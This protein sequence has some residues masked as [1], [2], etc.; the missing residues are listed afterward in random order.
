MEEKNG[1]LEHCKWGV[2]PASVRKL[3]QTL[4]M[5]QSFIDRLYQ[6]RFRGLS[7]SAPAVTSRTT[8][9]QLVRSVLQMLQGFSSPLFYW[10]DR[11]HTFHVKNDIHVAH[12]SLSSLSDILSRFIHAANCL[13]LVEEF[14]KHIRMYSQMYP[15]TMKAFTDSVFERLKNLRKIALS[16]EEK[17]IKLDNGTKATLLALVEN[18]KCICA[19]A[20]FLLQIVREAV[21]CHYLD[22]QYSMHASELAVHI[23]DY[24]YLKLN[25]D[26]LVQD[27]EDAAYHT[28]LILFI[29]SLQPLIHGLDDWLYEGILDDPFEELFFHANDAIT[30][31]EASFW[32]KG[33]SLRRMASRAIN[34]DDTTSSSVKQ[35][36][37]GKSGLAKSRADANDLVCP[38]FLQE[39]AKPIVSAGKSLQLLRHV[40]GVHSYVYNKEQE[41]ENSSFSALK[42]STTGNLSQ[43]IMDS[44]GT[45]TRGFLLLE[46][47]ELTDSG[48]PDNEPASQVKHMLHTKGVAGLTLSELFCISFVALVA[49]NIHLCK[50]F[51]QEY[52]WSPE[53]ARIC[54]SFMDE[55]NLED[56]SIDK[57]SASTSKGKIW[58]KFFRETILQKEHVNKEGGKVYRV[59][60]LSGDA[61][62]G[63]P[64]IKHLSPHNPH[65]GICSRLLEKNH[66][67]WEKLSVSTFWFL[68]PLNDKPLREA[69]FG[70]SNDHIATDYISCHGLSKLDHNSLKDIEA[71]YPFP[72]VLPCFQEGLPVMD[73]LPYQKNSSVVLRVLSWI[74]HLDV[75]IQL[76]PVVI[77]QE[78]LT[79]YIKKQ[80]DY[81]GKQILSKLMNSWR[82]LDELAVLRSIYLLGSGDLLQ[83]FST[84]LFDKLDEGEPWDDYFELNTMLQDSIRNS[85]DG[86]LLGSPDSLTVTISKHHNEDSDESQPSLG[87]SLL[88]SG[89]QFFGINAFDMLEF[90]YKVSWPLEV[91]ANQDAMRKYNQVLAFLLKVKRAKFVLDKTRRWMWKD[92]SS[93]NVSHKHQLLPQQKLLHFVDAFHQYVMDRVLHNAW[94]ELG[95]GM[96]SARSLDEVIEVHESYLISIQRQCFVASD[97]LLV[98][99]ASRIKSILGLALD[100]H[101]IQRT[102]RSGGAA[103]AIKARCEMEVDRIEK[104][105]D[106]CIAFLLKV[107]SSKT[108]VGHF[109]H[110]ADLVTRINYNYFYMSDDGSL[111]TVPGVETTASRTGQ[112]KT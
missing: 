100:F 112:P 97:K 20:E 62:L 2:L 63:R 107:L 79:V 19:G 105:F 99:I 30:I 37:F 78:C 55:E 46:D 65:V 47:N 13:Q 39:L 67:L 83:Q 98:L 6:T 68:P 108:N 42:S 45:K 72:T 74:Q 51:N 14:V 34:K 58:C 80:V 93:S 60:D 22:A 88:I 18:L 90:T 12:L 48:Y 96:G 26:C 75:K 21:P 109:P 32:Q 16:E 50:Y 17:S 29:S 28:L 101:A 15:P 5:A 70:R 73:F 106:D 52:P 9:A 92:R 57:R 103:P 82:L 38:L 76:L 59:H 33:Y 31:D 91:I 23:L 54:K 41:F 61:T 25:E 110:L 94:L 86:T 43:S 102:L 81:V 11:A 85:A 35:L 77:V 89:N 66:P 10:D 95:E 40:P 104:Q 44:L 49:D 24:L 8:E 84:V 36:L 56:N 53:I 4:K 111:L 7:F 69:I 3:E 1:G 27:G 87:P 71:L 64:S